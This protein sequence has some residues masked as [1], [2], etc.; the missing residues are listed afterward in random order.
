VH[1][2]VQRSV[3]A[4]LQLDCANVSGPWPDPFNLLNVDVFAMPSEVDMK[5][6]R[7]SREVEER[8]MQFLKDVKLD[9]RDEDGKHWI[10]CGSLRGVRLRESCAHLAADDHCA[11]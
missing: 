10:C 7:A 4:F 3:Q 11:S 5:C 8:S 9:L 1:C 6:G 2:T